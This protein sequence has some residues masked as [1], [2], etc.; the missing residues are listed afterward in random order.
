M[1]LTVD[2]IIW[3]TGLIIRK[4]IYHSQ[5]YWCWLSSIGVNIYLQGCDVCSEY[6]DVQNQFIFWQVLESLP[7]WNV[8]KTNLCILDHHR[9]ILVCII[10]NTYHQCAIAIILFLRKGWREKKLFFIN[11]Q[12]LIIPFLLNLIS[13]RLKPDE[14]IIFAIVYGVNQY[15]WSVFIDSKLLNAFE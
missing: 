11:V 13:S 14:I 4:V 10:F 9:T 12:G 7:L 5:C 15:L 6:M 2:S 3:S 1:Y 8:T